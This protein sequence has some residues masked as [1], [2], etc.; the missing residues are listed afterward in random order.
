M[1]YK[2]ILEQV[3]ETFE[4]ASNCRYQGFVSPARKSH[5]NVLD[6]SYIKNRCVVAQNLEDRV[7]D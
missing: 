3:N 7:L 1:I 2:K 4:R 6:W 5:Y